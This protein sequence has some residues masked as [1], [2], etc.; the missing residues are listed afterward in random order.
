MPEVGIQPTGSRIIQ[1]FKMNTGRQ[2]NDKK[3]SVKPRGP[4]D[5]CTCPSCI[6]TKSHA[7]GD[8]YDLTKCPK[9]NSPKKKKPSGK[10]KRS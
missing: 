1:V 9:Y 5:D 4:G 7:P 10:D 3:K 6:F 2:K 8:P